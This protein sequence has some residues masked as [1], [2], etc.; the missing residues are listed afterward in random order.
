MTIKEILG[1]QLKKVI[2]DALYAPEEEIQ[3]FSDFVQPI[4]NANPVRNNFVKSATASGT[5]FT[6]SKDK[7]FFLTGVTISLANNAVAESSVIGSIEVIMPNGNTESII[8]LVMKTNATF[9]VDQFQ[10]ININPT[11]LKRGSI[12]SFSSSAT[13]SRA[14]VIGFEEE[15]F[16]KGV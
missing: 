13:T 9:G 5:V 2:S 1:G 7:D 10:T 4:L 3:G 16:R 6:T 11:K 15:S 14:T 8:A 12:V